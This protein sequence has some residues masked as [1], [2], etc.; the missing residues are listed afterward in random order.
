MKIRLTISLFILIFLCAIPIWSE[1]SDAETVLQAFCDSFK[2][3]DDVVLHV[4]NS[5]HSATSPE[6]EVVQDCYFYNNRG[7]HQQTYG[8]IQDFDAVTGKVYRDAYGPDPGTQFQTLFSPQTSG[9]FLHEHRAIGENSEFFD[10]YEAGEDQKRVHVMHHG[11]LGPVLGYVFPFSKE[12]LPDL[13]SPDI[14]TVKEE[15]V[16]G[17]LAVIVE[18][19]VPEGHI[20]LWLSPEKGYAMEKCRLT[21]VAGKDLRYNG[22]LFPLVSSTLGEP[23]ARTQM[24]FE[25]DVR[26]HELI[27]KQYVPIQM[28]MTINEEMEGSKFFKITQSIKLSEITMNPDEEVLDAFEFI[29][30][31]EARVR[32]R[33]RDGGVLS[34][35]KWEDGKLV[36]NIDS[37]ALDDNIRTAL[38]QIKTGSPSKNKNKGGV[39]LQMDGLDG[40]SGFLFRHGRLL[41]WISGAL[42]LLAC[43]AVGAFA[44]KSS[45]EKTNLTEADSPTDEESS[46]ASEGL[47]EHE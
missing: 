29:V 31:E 4:H 13:L 25:I 27:E 47:E 40:A 19:T 42:F 14:V 6:F 22:E 34:G 3:M 18:A 39:T 36:A 37:V 23:L 30:P 10:I 38:A 46:H 21:K 44:Y 11:R 1:S 20:E 5:G 41:T 2:W 7:I 35:F 26:K 9:Y 33:K 43:G 15:V 28:T 45:K 32:F 16:D 17:L 12:R 24:I 8:T